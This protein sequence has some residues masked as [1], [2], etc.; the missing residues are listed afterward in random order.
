[1]ENKIFHSK[2]ELQA[3]FCAIGREKTVWWGITNIKNVKVGVSTYDVEIRYFPN[4]EQAAI[5]CTPKNEQL[6]LF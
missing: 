4:S 5:F 3:F 6:D 2:E 1:M